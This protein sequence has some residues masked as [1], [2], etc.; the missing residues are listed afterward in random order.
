MI[1]APVECFRTLISSSIILETSYILKGILYFAAK[2]SSRP[3]TLDRNYVYVRAHEWANGRPK[4]GVSM[5]TNHLRWELKSSDKKKCFSHFGPL[6]FLLS[7][8]SC[9]PR[10]R[11]RI[12]CRAVNWLEEPFEGSDGIIGGHT[13]VARAMGEDCYSPPLPGFGSDCARLWLLPSPF[14]WHPPAALPS[15]AFLSS[16]SHTHVL[17]LSQLVAPIRT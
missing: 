1:P 17:P 14:N 13:Q 7:E 15:L 16:P 4:Y 10:M 8:I 3:D 11:E 2:I 12:L 9:Y 5:M 6:T